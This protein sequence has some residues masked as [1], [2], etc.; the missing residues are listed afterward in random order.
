MAYTKLL[1][2]NR[3][4]SAPLTGSQSPSPLPFLILELGGGGRKEKKRWCRINVPF[5]YS[6]DV[7][8]GSN[9]K[10]TFLVLGSEQSRH[11]GHRSFSHKNGLNM[12]TMQRETA[13][14]TSAFGVYT[15]Y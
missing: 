2:L 15:S 1:H 13:L 7:N 14:G 6:I 8:G 10:R 12:V 11:R 9:P 5:S 4:V 3:S